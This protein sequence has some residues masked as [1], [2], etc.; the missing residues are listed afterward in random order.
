MTAILNKH[1]AGTLL[2]GVR[3]NGAIAG[4]DALREAIINAFCHRDYYGP[5]YIQMA[6][7]KDRV[8]ILNPGTLYGNLTIED[9]RN[10]N[11][12]QRRS[13]SVSSH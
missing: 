12:S 2:F 1:Q 7:F 8:E 10:G 9:L 5:D 3:N 6:I 4:V 11:V 13:R